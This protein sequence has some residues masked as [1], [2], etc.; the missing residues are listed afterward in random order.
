MKG[1]QDLFFFFQREGCCYVEILSLMPH[2]KVH[3]F[4]LL[5]KSGEKP[6][7]LFIQLVIPQGEDWRFSNILEKRIANTNAIVSHK[8]TL[9]RQH[10]A[11][12]KMQNKAGCKI[13][14]GGICGM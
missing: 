12:P 3:F 9:R 10:P 14:S 1:L 4:P 2:S 7:F 13:I 6:A 5:Q 11:L 8:G